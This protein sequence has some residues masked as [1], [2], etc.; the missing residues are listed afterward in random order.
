MGRKTDFKAN[1]GW[2]VGPQNF[3]KILNGNYKNHEGKKDD[4]FSG[5]AIQHE[6]G[7]GQEGSS[8]SKYAGIGQRITNDE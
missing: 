1:L 7:N 2:M 5:K 3:E 4:K 8:G 6:R